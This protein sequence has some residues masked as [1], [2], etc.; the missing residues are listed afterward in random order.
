MAPEVWNKAAL[1]M[2][3]KI[4]GSDQDISTCRPIVLTILLGKMLE[5]ILKRQI[6]ENNNAFK[7]SW[8]SRVNITP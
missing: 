8:V 5:K 6:R 4:K 3:C 2:M 7:H 1:N